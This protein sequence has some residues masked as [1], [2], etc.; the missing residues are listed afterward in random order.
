[1]NKTLK[2]GLTVLALMATSSAMAE[3]T[4][5]SLTTKGYVDAG[6]TAVHNEIA[7]KADAAT[8]YTKTE[9]NNL[10]DDKAD[11]ADV[12]TKTEV[13][14]AIQNVSS[15]T[16]A[17]GVTVTNGTASITGLSST[18]SNDNKMYVLKNNTATELTVASDWA[19]EGPSWAQQETQTTP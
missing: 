13:D 9:V 18:T 12:Y 17:N 15:V 4:N 10:L 3:V 19:T 5:S 16:G 11:A 14:Q 2:G 7:D 8:T 1:M 6:L